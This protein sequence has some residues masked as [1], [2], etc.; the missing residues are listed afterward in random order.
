MYPF[1]EA[2]KV[3]FSLPPL[4]LAMRVCVFSFLVVEGFVSWMNTGFPSCL[5]PV[6]SCMSEPLRGTVPHLPPVFRAKHPVE[7]CGEDLTT[8]QTQLASS[9]SKLI[10]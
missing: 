8:V 4:S 2:D 5:Q 6:V 7:A 3:C 1:L 9:Y 10:L